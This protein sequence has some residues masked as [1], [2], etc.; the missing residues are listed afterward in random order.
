VLDCG[1]VVFDVTDDAEA[2][3]EHNPQQPPG[4]FDVSQRAPP[5]EN[6]WVD[7]P[8]PDA[9]HRAVKLRAQNFCPSDDTFRLGMR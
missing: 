9:S 1:T 2:F 3:A 7:P 8:S 4:A 5:C 6:E